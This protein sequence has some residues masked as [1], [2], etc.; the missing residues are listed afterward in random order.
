MTFSTGAEVM[1]DRVARDQPRRTTTQRVAVRRL[2]AAMIEQTRLGAALER[3]AGTSS[4]QSAYARLR[5]AS[6]R[7]K[8]CDRDVQELA[9]I[10]GRA[11]PGG[12]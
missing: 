5:A 8:A 12:D 10:G 11:V 3:A 6:Q 1:M 2:E 9:G 4:E 7:V